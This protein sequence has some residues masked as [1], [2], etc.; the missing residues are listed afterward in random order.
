MYSTVLV[1]RVRELKATPEGVKSM[2]KE[3]EELIKLGV[4]DGRAEGRVE[5]R[6]EGKVEGKTEIQREVAL[7]LDRRGM[8]PDEIAE[9]TGAQAATIRIWLDKDLNPIKE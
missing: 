3:L 8:H 9:I 7:A 6:V 5:G 1:K 4:A 2:C